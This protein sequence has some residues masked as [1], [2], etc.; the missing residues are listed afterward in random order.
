MTH[1]AFFTAK[2]II[3]EK[4]DKNEYTIAT[5]ITPSGFIHFGNFREVI[6]G[7]FIAKALKKMGKKVRLIFSWDD[8]DTFRKVPAGLENKNFE[9]Y[10]YQ[11]ISR[12]PDPF[13]KEHS[14]ADFFKKNFEKELAEVG[15]EVEFISQTKKYQ[16]GDYNKDILE[17]LEKKDQIIAILNQYRT[18]PLNQDWLPVACYCSRCFKD[19]MEKMTY[20]QGELFYQCH[21]SHKEA[22]DVLNSHQ[23]KLPWRIDW[24]MRWRY[25]KVDFE[26][27]GKDHSSDGGSSTT[28]KLIAKEVF[29]YEPPTYLQYDFVSYKGLGGKMSSSK[30]NLVRLKDVLEIYPREII[31]WIFASY[32]PN[33]D[34]AISF[35]LDVIKTYDA[36]DRFKEKEDDL[37]EEIKFLID[38][39]SKKEPAFRHFCNILQIHNKNYE[40]IKKKYQEDIQERFFKAVYWLNHYAPEEFL[41]QLKEEQNRKINHHQDFYKKLLIL[42]NKEFKEDK[43]LHEDL[44]ALIHEFN[45]DPKAT[46]QEIYLLLIDKDH[47][48][49]LAHFILEI[50]PEKVQNLINAAL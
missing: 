21:C 44:Y 24:P 5:G 7:Y 18:E 32:K 14:Y 40:E 6:T 23:L 45:L 33:V 22:L 16:S 8:Y 36:Y 17:V 34:F 28:A 15:I 2:K 26:A 37:S 19:K 20:S 13:E 31:F 9:Q 41:F 3:Q 35:D 29:N 27:A 10:L 50:G 30:G 25:E 47:G 11:P 48:P 12:I 4:G 43:E 42:L 39:Q 1:W 38:F 49:K 46:F